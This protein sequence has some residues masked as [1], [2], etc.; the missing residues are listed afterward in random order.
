MLITILQ[1]TSSAEQVRNS[2]A[3]I[4]IDSKHSRALYLENKFSNVK[5]DSFSNMSAYCQELKT[6]SDQLSNVDAPV[7]NDRLVLQLI[8]RLG[9]KYENIATHLQQS[10]PLPDFYTVR[11]K[12]ILEETRKA[13]SVANS[14]AS[15]H[16]VADKQ[17]TNQ[18]AVALNTQT[19]SSEQQQLHRGGSGSRGQPYRGSSNS[20]RGGR[21]HGRGRGRGRGNNIGYNL[22]Y[23][24]NYV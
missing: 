16:V 13:H 15:L 3:Q 18:S 19:E 21:G 17:T 11:S 9:E 22:N 4:F 14:T 8:A 12:L 7:S 5:L 23:G 10:T 1:H 6:L 2:L 20:N 24:H